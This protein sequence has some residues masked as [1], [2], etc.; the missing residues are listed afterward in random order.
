MKS[1]AVEREGEKEEKLG[2]KR[3]RSALVEINGCRFQ[4]ILPLSVELHV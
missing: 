3:V 2:K 4:R 1:T